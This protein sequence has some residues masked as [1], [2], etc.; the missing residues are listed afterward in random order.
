MADTKADLDR[1]LATVDAD[2]DA[3]LERLF[4]LLAIPSISTDPAY[5]AECRRAGQ[6]LVEDLEGL[7]FTAKLNE[8]PGH[9][10][11]TARSEG[12]APRRV[13]F[14]GH[15][16]VQP[17]DPLELWNTPPFEAQLVTAEDGR[18]RI[19]ARG[20]ADDK[21]QIMTFIEACRA[22]KKVAGALPV[23]VTLML[24]GE[25]E[26]GSLNL[27][28]FVAANRE[29]LAADLALV[30]DTGMWDRETPAI[31]VSLRG[32]MHEEIVVHCA[33]RDLHSG[34]YGGAAQ[35][36]LHVIAKIIA[37]VHDADGRVTIPGFYD[38]VRETPD[39]VKQQ[40]AGL[41][42]TAENFLGPIGLS[43]PSGEKD[44]MLIELVS[45]RPTFEVNGMWG[46]Y[47]GAG[48]KTVIPSIATAKIS[49]RLVADQDP[50]HV[51][52]VVRAFIKARI[53]ADC[54]V[55][56]RGGEG[57]RA[58]AVSHDSPDLGKAA[59]ALA[60]EWGKAPFTIG[61]GGSIP[62][63]GHFKK[64]LGQDSLLVGFSLDD[65]RIHSPNEKYDL[66][67]FHKGIRSWARILH[68]LAN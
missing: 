18:K 2:L 40:W 62:I 55:E 48:S 43:V 6:W 16:D 46:G 24:E 56:F 30:C 42:M 54:R 44:R 60:D 20:S 49:C 66:T 5:K 4:A 35:N 52:D 27:P 51:R 57:S 25:E 41:G 39:E 34:Y 61:A 53:P 59:Q 21:G 65:D 13:M 63:V 11:V 14:Y 1:V 26:S 12:G 7:G 31:T 22:W 45:S 10:V 64:Q 36:P 37:D 58:V 67:S 28:P 32:L 3:S 29:A 17:V 8:T 19:V 38:N 33:D 15:Y 23:E 47:T 9:P 68:A 50:L